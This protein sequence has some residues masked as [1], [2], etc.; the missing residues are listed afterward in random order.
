MQFGQ[1]GSQHIGH[2][3][4]GHVQLRLE[5]RFRLGRSHA[6]VFHLF[7]N[8]H[9]LR[10]AR[11]H[12]SINP[13]ALQYADPCFN[14]VTILFG[15]LPHAVGHELLGFGRIDLGDILR[16][17]VKVRGFVGC[18]HARLLGI[19]KPAAVFFAG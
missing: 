14:E 10:Q 7:E 15:G 1:L 18:H 3:I 16:L 11:V 9:R 19:G 2:I 17:L 12:G 4:F 6:R 5:E 8:V 13:L